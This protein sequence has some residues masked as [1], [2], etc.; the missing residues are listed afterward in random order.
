[1]NKH[2]KLALNDSTFIMDSPRFSYRGLMID[3]ARHFIP[4]NILKKQ[5][6]AMSYNKFNIFHWYINNKYDS[7]YLF[8]ML[9]KNDK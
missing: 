5:I 7:K 2:K 1:M 3:T 8:L 4:V 6:D 9:I